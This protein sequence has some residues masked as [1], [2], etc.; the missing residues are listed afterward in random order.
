MSV[1]D[2]MDEIMQQLQA[3]GE[4]DNTLVIFTSDNGYLWGEHGRDKKFVPYLPSVKVPF[5]MRWDGHLPAGTVDNRL[6]VNVDVASTVLEAAGVSVPVGKPALEGESLLQPSNR[7]VIYSEYFKDSAN[8][9][10]PEWASLYFGDSQFIVT[11]KADGTV[12]FREYYDHLT[13]PLQNENV[14]KDANPNNNLTPTRLNELN[15][16]VNRL[17]TA[18]GAAMIE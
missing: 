5:Y 17:R 2:V 6:T 13:D 4:L 10:M 7:S 18:S 12:S 11:Y 14:Q 8:G 15:A 1:D 9:P 16:Q 3:S